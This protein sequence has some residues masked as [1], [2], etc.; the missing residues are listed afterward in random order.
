MCFCFGFGSGFAL[1]EWYGG[2]YFEDEV[3]FGN[4]CFEKVVESG[5]MQRHAEDFALSSLLLRDFE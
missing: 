1:V 2:G 3:V 5:R 4:G